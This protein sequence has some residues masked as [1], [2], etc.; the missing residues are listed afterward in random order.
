MEKRG[1]LLESDV[2]KSC[3]IMSLC[4]EPFPPLFPQPCSIFLV[5]NSIRSSEANLLSETS[6][7][8]SEVHRRIDS[9]W[10]DAEQKEVEKWECLP[11][12][13]TLTHRKSHDSQR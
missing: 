11:S 6:P 5:N 10:T 4:I 9:E 1:S 3:P 13:P 8:V 12:S 7:V 2:K